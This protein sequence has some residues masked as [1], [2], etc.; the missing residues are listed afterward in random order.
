MAK[1]KQVVKD[2]KMVYPAKKMAT[3]MMKK[4]KWKLNSYAVKEITTW[5]AWSWYT[6]EALRS[7]RIGAE[8]SK[9]NKKKKKY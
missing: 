4:P 1:A 8:R 6:M 9:N 5:P 7:A 3:G 2:G